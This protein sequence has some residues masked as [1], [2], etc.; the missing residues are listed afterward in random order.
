MGRMRIGEGGMDEARG[1]VLRFVRPPETG[2]NDQQVQKF[3]ES[4]HDNADNFVWSAGT[5]IMDAQRDDILTFAGLPLVGGS[6]SGG[7]LINASGLGGNIGLAVGRSQL[8][9]AAVDTIFSEQLLPFISYKFEKV[10]SGPNKGS[11]D[12]LVGNVLTPFLDVTE[13]LNGSRTGLSAELKKHYGTQVVKDFI[14]AGSLAPVVYRGSDELSLAKVTKA[15]KLGLVFKKTNPIAAILDLLP[16]TAITYAL[17]L[18]YGGNPL[19]DAVYSGLAVTSRIAKSISWSTGGDPLVLDFSGTGLVTSNLGDSNVHFDL[20]DDF[21]SERT[22]WLTGNAG[23]LVFDKNA[24]G[25]VDDANELFGNFEN[26]GFTDLKRY[27]DLHNGVKDGIIKAND[28][29]FSKLQ[30][31]IDS[32]SDGISQANELH[33]LNDLGI[34]SISLNSIPLGG[35]TPEGTELRAA[36]SFT[37]NGVT[38]VIYEA[39][40]PTDQTN[41]V[42]RGE[43]GKTAW[44]S[45]IAGTKTIDVKGFGRVTNLAVA[46]ANDFEPA[47]LVA[48]RSATASTADFVGQQLGRL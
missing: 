4:G 9:I 16:P 48:S 32:N 3:I 30:V 42:Y 2:A 44:A 41:T 36:A 1:E 25:R 15:A 33:S 21:F 26:S 17:Q 5:T 19:V 27:D 8:R 6:D 46:A 18:A 29:I 34:S 35:V 7:I 39:I 14:P 43:S 12:L 37:Q 22:A 45:T 24:N 11:Y 28:A 38:R 47:D 40:F 13:L 31:W 23:F 10:T 20:N